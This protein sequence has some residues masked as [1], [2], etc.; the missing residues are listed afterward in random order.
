M[1]SVRQRLL[2]RHREPQLE[3]DITR[4]PALGY[5]AP[6]EIPELRAALQLLERSRHDIEFFGLADRAMAHWGA[7]KAAH[8]LGMSDSRFG[9]LA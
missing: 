3:R 7:L 4:S 5:E 9:S 1:T 2:A 6:E 8:G